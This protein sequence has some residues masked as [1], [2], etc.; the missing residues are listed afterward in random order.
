MEELQ[1]EKDEK[2]LRR[3]N[4]LVEIQLHDNMDASSKSRKGKEPELYV[5]DGAGDEGKLRSF[6]DRLLESRARSEETGGRGIDALDFEPEDDDEDEQ[7]VSERQS[8]EL[9]DESWEDTIWKALRPD[10]G[11]REPSQLIETGSST[12]AHEELLKMFNEGAERLKEITSGTDHWFTE[13]DLY[14]AKISI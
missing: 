14:R 3:H 13:I 11:L 2:K 1:W 9:E 12:E 5:I 10:D 6:P 7:S 8:E 4:K